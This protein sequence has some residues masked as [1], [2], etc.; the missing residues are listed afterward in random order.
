[1]SDK[2]VLGYWAIRGLG[3]RVRHLLEYTGLPYEEV[4][5]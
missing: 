5:Y 3:E 1:M 2:L 4:R